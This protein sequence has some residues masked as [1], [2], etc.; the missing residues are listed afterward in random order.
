MLVSVTGNLGEVGLAGYNL[1]LSEFM[2]FLPRRTM[3]YAAGCPF[4]QALCRLENPLRTLGPDGQLGIQAPSLEYLQGSAPW[5]P[6]KLNIELADQL[7]WSSF[8]HNTNQMF[9]GKWNFANLD[10]ADIDGENNVVHN[11]LYGRVG[12]VANSH[13]FR[14]PN[15]VGLYVPAENDF[16]WDVWSWE[17][18]SVLKVDTRYD[19][20]TSWFRRP[21][22]CLRERLD[23]IQSVGI[24]TVFD[25]ERDGTTYT[26]TNLEVEY[27]GHGVSF[28]SYVVDRTC[29]SW[30]VN[31]H[32]SVLQVGISFSLERVNARA[33]TP[34]QPPGNSIAYLC[35]YQIEV[36]VNEVF[37]SERQWSIPPVVSPG[38]LLSIEEFKEVPSYVSSIG[39]VLLTGVSSSENRVRDLVGGTVVRAGDNRYRA[40]AVWGDRVGGL[41]RDL[42]GAMALGAQK[43]L[44]AV[45]EQLQSN[46]IEAA[47][48][49]AE[50]HEM[51]DFPKTLDVLRSSRVR[52]KIRFLRLIP[53]ILHVLSDSKLLWS[54]GLAPTYDDATE[55]AEKSQIIWRNFCSNPTGVA[56]G[57][58][59]LV[60]VPDE[61]LRDFPSTK[62]VFKTVIRYR[63]DPDS[64]IFTLLKLEGIGVL[65]RLRSVWDLMPG[66]FILDWVL[67]VGAALEIADKGMMIMLLDSVYTVNGINV[68]WNFPV[69]VE[70]QYDFRVLSLD[71]FEQKRAG[72]RFFERHV[73]NGVPSLSATR[74]PILAANGPSDWILA[75]ALAYKFFA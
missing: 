71:Q 22:G 14:T 1:S 59:V 62:A 46:H 38:P 16:A 44:D 2:N 52:G 73:L 31:Y 18:P 17:R 23:Y 48:E 56:R 32:R 4:G 26:Y 27:A 43:A 49:F 5:A 21:D 12:P 9:S 69:D 10:Y 41:R 60:D 75:G 6:V 65:P 72:Y 51:I 42:Y 74:L 61:L 55:I 15:Q 67:N 30:P 40:H 70:D 57:K 3:Y 13:Q 50:L 28:V 66:S 7:R 63:Y 45:F 47:V 53:A 54:L 37:Y 33:F 29:W 64:L 35:D 34:G 39:A 25:G 8:V 36:K 11:N 19:T 24:G 58:G 68:F 20:W